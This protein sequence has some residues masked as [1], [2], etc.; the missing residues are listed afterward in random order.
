MSMTKNDCQGFEIEPG[1]Y[2]GCTANDT[3]ASDCPVCGEL[4]MTPLEAQ[5]TLAALRPRERVMAK[6]TRRKRLY[7]RLLIFASNLKPSAVVAI[8]TVCAVAGVALALGAL[9]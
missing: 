2:S 4:P 5:A 7:L 9:R 8:L 1:V 6:L 3:G